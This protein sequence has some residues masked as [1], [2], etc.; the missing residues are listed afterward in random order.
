M[1]YEDFTDYDQSSDPNT[2]QTVATNKLSWADMIRNEICYLADD[3]GVNHF[4]GDF[5]HKLE[6]QYHE[7]AT[8]PL[9]AFWILANITDSF[10][11]IENASEDAM[12]LYHFG[13]VVLRIGIIENGSTRVDTFASSQDTIYYVTIGRDDD[14]GV[15]NTGQLVA[16]IRTGSHAGNLE[17]TL[18]LDCAAGE[19]NDFRYIYALDSHEQGVPG[20]GDGYTER[21]DLQ[22]AVGVGNAG[23]MTTNTGFWG[24]TF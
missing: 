15:N 2:R 24:P 7:D 9:A 20:Q 3:K 14:G 16:Y 13:D 23:I 22:E 12:V 5:E 11:G 10:T 4:S 8:D 6:I 17:D 21:L 1:A 19:Q 18:T